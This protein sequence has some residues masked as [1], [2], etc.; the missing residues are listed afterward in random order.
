MTYQ[1]YMNFVSLFPTLGVFVLFL[2]VVVV[3]LH[4]LFIKKEKLFVSLISVYT[5]FVLMVVVPMF[6]TTVS[7]WLNIHPYIRAGSFA[8]L[9]IVLFI[10]LSFSN[11][12]WFSQKTSPTRFITSLVYRK[13]IVGLFFTT[14]LYFVPET[15]KAQFGN[16][17][18]WLFMN[19]IAM[20][21]WFL[22]PLFL[23]FAYRFKTRRGWIE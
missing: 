10:I 7:G 15:L 9:C 8:V 18:Y 17:I 22:I 19:L 21:V 4:L 13:A 1:H 5:S 2:Y 11:I 3:L 20:I 12:N 23:V 16:I 6:S 14:I